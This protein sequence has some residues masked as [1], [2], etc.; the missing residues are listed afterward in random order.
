MSLAAAKPEM[1]GIAASSSFTRMQNTASMGAQA[2]RGAFWNILFSALNKL[3]AFGGQIAL[4]WFLLPQDMGLAGIALAVTSIVSIASGTI[5]T[6]LL[7]QHE[8]SFEE[9]AGEIFW[10]SLMMNFAATVLLVALSPLAG[11]LFKDA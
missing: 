1:A 3:V 11:H 7:I 8:G 10:F 5:P 9:N 2:A 6:I 4:A